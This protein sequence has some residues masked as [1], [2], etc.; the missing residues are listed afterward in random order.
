[1]SLIQQHYHRKYLLLNQFLVFPYFFFEKGTD[2][3][4]DTLLIDAFDK[5]IL[6]IFVFG[7]I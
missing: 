5:G 7:L 2:N 4:N 3:S 1:M 6:E